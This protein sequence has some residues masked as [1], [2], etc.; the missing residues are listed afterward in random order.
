MSA[1][2]VP[3]PEASEIAQDR[4]S[5]DDWAALESLTDKQRA[6]VFEYMLDMNGTRAAQRAGYAGGDDALAVRG[7]MLMRHPVVNP[8]IRKL[9][10]GTA[11]EMGYTREWIID[12]LEEIVSRV[13]EG[14]PKVHVTKDGDMF[15]V[16]DDEGNTVRE[17]QPG[18]AKGALELLARLRG[19]MVERVEHDVRHV[20]VQV[21][22]VDV[23]DLR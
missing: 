7:S 12:R 1:L 2:A 9:T 18:A 13:M 20:V 10:A 22:G 5:R 21:N 23:E 11:D 14:V 17:W 8:L 4:L 16:K 19:D 6:F 3:D 15:E